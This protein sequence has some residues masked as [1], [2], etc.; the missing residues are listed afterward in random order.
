MKSGNNYRKAYNRTGR[1]N[2]SSRTYSSPPRSYYST[3]AYNGYRSRNTQQSS[4]GGSRVYTRGY[5]GYSS[6]NNTSVA[7][8]YSYRSYNKAVR[9]KA[10]RQ[11]KQKES[12]AL[13][14][15]KTFATIAIL[16]I[17]TLSLL[18]THASN[19]SRRENIAA[20]K[21]E[22]ESIQEDNE[23]LRTS[24][25]DNLDLKTIEQEA[26]KLGLQKPA[27]YQITKINVPKESYTVQYDTQPNVE[28]QSFWEYIKSLFKD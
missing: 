3:T 16:F 18:C 25:E 4:G 26:L 22:L 8:D 23:Y 20:M 5:S 27:E 12:I 7:H 17:F 28:E 15:P 10:V 1:Y 13:S 19:S 11:H 6:Y 9:R 24:I 2:T 21:A 14:L